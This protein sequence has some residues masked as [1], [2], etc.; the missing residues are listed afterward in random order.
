MDDAVAYVCWEAESLMHHLEGASS[1]TDLLQD[2]CKHGGKLYEAIRDS[3]WCIYFQHGDTGLEQLAE[4]ILEN[5]AKLDRYEIKHVVE[6]SFSGIG[7]WLAHGE[8]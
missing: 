3:G 1:S 6:H 2:D 8:Y 4:A 5:T 7:N